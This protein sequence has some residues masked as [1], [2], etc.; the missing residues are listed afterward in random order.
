MEHN[1]ILSDE[2]YSN[3]ADETHDHYHALECTPSAQVGQVAH[4]C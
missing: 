2:G 1:N 3:Y 4:H